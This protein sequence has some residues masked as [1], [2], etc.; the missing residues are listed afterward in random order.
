MTR[1]ACHTR[2]G[3]IRDGKSKP[4]AHRCHAEQS[5]CVCVCVCVSRKKIAKTK[6][7][8][9]CQI[10]CITT[11]NL[12]V[13]LFTLPLPDARCSGCSV[14]ESRPLLKGKKKNPKELCLNRTRVL[15]HV[16]TFNFIWEIV[17]FLCLAASKKCV[18]LCLRRS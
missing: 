17:R 1:N 11:Q 6:K 14:D 15:F 16:L 13:F 12:L 9:L 8:N 10:L 2:R 5:V 18:F 7:T 3:M 4:H